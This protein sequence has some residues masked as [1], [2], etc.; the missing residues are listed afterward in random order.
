MN[1]ERDPERLARVAA[2]VNQLQATLN[3]HTI[4]DGRVAIANAIAAVCLNSESN[5]ELML[6]SF[7]DSMS[8]VFH[9]M[10]RLRAAASGTN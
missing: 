6:R 7:M 4:A 8:T 9:E 3:G 10:R 5:P 1:D 2:L